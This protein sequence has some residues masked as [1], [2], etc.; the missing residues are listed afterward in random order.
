[1]SITFEFAVRDDC[2]DKMVPSDLRQLV[3]E[4]DHA[5]S[6]VDGLTMTMRD[7]ASHGCTSY[8]V[9]KDGSHHTC[10]DDYDDP[11]MDNFDHDDCCPVCLARLALR[12]K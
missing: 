11:M 6:E 3:A 4:R 10:V 5:L 2:L 7:I 9:L 12:K 1:M 8:C